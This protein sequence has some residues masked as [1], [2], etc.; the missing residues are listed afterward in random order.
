MDV[1][2][3]LD[4]ALT[5]L[6]PDR[7]T[8][9]CEVSLQGGALT[10]VADPGLEPDLRTLAAAHGL[11]ARV[12]YP[13]PTVRF[14]HA[15]RL[16]LSARPDL[17]GEAVDEAL[18]GEE[19]RVYD[20]DGDL[21]RVALQRDG[22][23]GWMPATALSTHLPDPSH[24]FVRLR[25]HLYAGPHVRQ[26]R[27]V[28]LS[29]GTR[30]AVLSSQD[31]WSRV[32][33]CDDILFAPERSLAPLERP[34]PEFAPERL[35]RFA[36]RFRETPYQWGGITAWGLDCSGLVQTAYGRFGMPLPRDSDQQQAA[37]RSVARSD[38]APGDLL[39]FPGHVAI[40]LGGN[41]FVHANAHHMRVTV[42]ELGRGD[43]GRRLE[44]A[45]SA[46]RRPHER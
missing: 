32:R 4:E 29:L 18:Y 23:L 8:V 13:E 14:V 7:R 19:V 5:A 43:Y 45:L 44:R 16:S 38:L 6:V 37:G 11:P 10:G 17:E 34:A 40:S 12:V 33:W 3:A 41:R 42:D 27:R 28:E 9:L 2:R 20:Q 39:F 30:L 24:R 22:Y 15:P 35:A 25:G 46:L 21:V 36:L 31:G 1:Q 26:P